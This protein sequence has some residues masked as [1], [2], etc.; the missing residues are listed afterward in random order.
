M[1]EESGVGRGGRDSSADDEGLVKAAGAMFDV[2]SSVC[3]AGHLLVLLNM[4]S[5][6]ESS[7][8]MGLASK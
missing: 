1:F 8:K 6:H 7:C 3:T 4:P 5:K 2:S